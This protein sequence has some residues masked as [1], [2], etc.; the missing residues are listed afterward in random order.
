MILGTTIYFVIVLKPFYFRPL[1]P[2]NKYLKG[3]FPI[4]LIKTADLQPDGK[5]LICSH[6]HGVM[7]AGIN[8]AV[9][10]DAC[11]W[12]EKYPG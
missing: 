2:I 8:C 5:Y 6:P 4:E 7:P 1:T 3:Y 9:G 10:T 12:N 11:G